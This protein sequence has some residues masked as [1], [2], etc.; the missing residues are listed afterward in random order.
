MDNDVEE[1][2]EQAQKE[3][4]HEIPQKEIE[5][6]IYIYFLKYFCVFLF[7]PYLF[8]LYIYFNIHVEFFCCRLKFF[9]VRNAKYM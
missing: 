5:L 3:E 9:N 7:F 6:G 4:K 8:F 2:E 1:K